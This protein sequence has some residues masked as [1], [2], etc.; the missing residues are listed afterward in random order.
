MIRYGT[1]VRLSRPFSSPSPVSSDCS[2]AF[3]CDIII[4]IITVIT[5]SCKRTKFLSIWRPLTGLMVIGLSTHLPRKQ[6]TRILPRSSCDR[7]PMSDRQAIVAADT[8]TWCRRTDYDVYNEILTT[9]SSCRLTVNIARGCSGGGELKRA[10]AS[11]VHGH[12]ENLRTVGA[13]TLGATN[14]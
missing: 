11:G 5:D 13:T 7:D 8:T 10:Q 3:S 9:G 14:E 1:V 6:R 2:W 12:G 4:I